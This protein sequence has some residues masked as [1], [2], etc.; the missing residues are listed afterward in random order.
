MPLKFNVRNESR[1]SS[2]IALVLDSD[3]RSQIISALF[4][5]HSLVVNAESSSE[6]SKMKTIEQNNELVLRLMKLSISVTAT[7]EFVSNGKQ[8]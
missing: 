4:A 3:I 6:E 7:D 5:N 8:I 2:R 1:P